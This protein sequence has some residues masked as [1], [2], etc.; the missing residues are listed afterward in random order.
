MSIA[1]QAELQNLHNQLKEAAQRATDL[2]EQIA[3]RDGTI[4][5]MNNKI[6]ELVTA[7]DLELQSLHSKLK[8]AATNADEL[9]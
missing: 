8:K 3:A 1:H 2:Q 5:V 4:T 6:H 7:H 9:S